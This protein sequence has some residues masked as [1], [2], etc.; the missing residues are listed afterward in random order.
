MRLLV[1]GGTGLVGYAI[2]KVINTQ[3]FDLFDDCLFLSSKNC[4]LRYDPI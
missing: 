4:D 2:N 3:F 1:T